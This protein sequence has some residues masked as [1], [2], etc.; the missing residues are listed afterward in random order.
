MEKLRSI[1]SSWDTNGDGKVSVEELM[2]EI[3]TNGD[4]KIDDNE[5]S[6]LVDQLSTQTTYTNK[7]LTQLQ[8]LEEQSLKQQQEAHTRET[9]LRRAMEA[10]DQ[11]R[12]DTNMLRSRLQNANDVIDQYRRDEHDQMAQGHERDRQVAALQKIVDQQAHD[13][14]N[15]KS[16][17]VDARSMLD[18]LQRSHA[19]GQNELED[20]KKKRAQE[21]ARFQVAAEETLREK[22]ILESKL[23]PL[24]QENVGLSEALKKQQESSSTSYAELQDSKTK[25]YTLQ[26]RIAELE[27]NEIAYKDKI[28]KYE[29]NERKHVSE[30]NILK[31]QF[32]DCND[33]LLNYK[34]EYE[35][36]RTTSQNLTNDNKLFK[37]R[38]VN[39]MNELDATQKDCIDLQ[40]LRKNEK[41][42]HDKALSLA[43]NDLSNLADEARIRH[44]EYSEQLTKNTN[45]HQEQLHT[46][47][48]QYVKLQDDYRSLHELLQRVQIEQTEQANI[49][50]TERKKYD[51]KILEGQAR[52]QRSEVENQD[53]YSKLKLLHSNLEQDVTALQRELIA[54]TENYVTNLSA[55]SGAVQQ[56][57]SS[58]D[59]QTRRIADITTNVSD[60][61]GTC[62]LASRNLSDPHVTQY[63]NMKRGTERLTTTVNDLRSSLL[64]H[65]DAIRALQLSLEEEK[66]RTIMLDE[67][68]S[69]LAHDNKIIRE[70]MDEI[71][72]TSTTRLEAT[73]R[74]ANAIM[75]LRDD[76]ERQL[77]RTLGQLEEAN[78]QTRSLQEQHQQFQNQLRDEQ[79]EHSS[80][81][82]NMD[83]HVSIIILFL[84][85][86]LI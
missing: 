23:A 74:E 81:M 21:Q 12:A 30:L 44:T 84:N 86:I 60:V 59:E 45:E 41:L 62:V 31:K 64:E 10:M 15:A 7:L 48:E 80:L 16:E 52:L 37:D 63:E 1:Q 17:V 33:S 69:R 71:K 68:R 40:E 18:R 83:G 32:N 34:A 47:D 73:K 82:S 56:V 43:Q 85:S 49:F 70:R 19:E 61:K 20:Q 72:M 46:R 25:V 22:R 58:Q 42:E 26:R 6:N 78:K 9:T 67:E 29:D 36:Y 8:S 14:D 3:D 2:K 51:N 27:Q 24:A 4:G 65:R 50:D 76:V 66:T 35:K 28:N 55:L 75:T 13:L 77:Q 5:I 53:K 79:N 11:A 38:L 57:R 39:L 54:R